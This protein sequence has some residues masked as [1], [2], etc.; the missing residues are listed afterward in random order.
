MKAF[1]P[2]FYFA[3]VISIGFACSN[4]TSDK[5]A[6]NEEAKVN[7]SPALI[8]EWVLISRQYPNDKVKKFSESPADFI[9]EFEKNGY[10]EVYDKIKL[11]NPDDKPFINRRRLGQWTIKGS[12]LMLIYEE[13]DSLMRQEMTIVSS[14]EKSLIVK[15]LK[16][17]VLL[18]DSFAK[19]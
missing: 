4:N 17:N 6:S 3:L 14:S 18:I 10:F 2:F 1:V 7:H 9:V 5:S 12:D 8:G 15:Q 16:N 11:T 19:K 13:N